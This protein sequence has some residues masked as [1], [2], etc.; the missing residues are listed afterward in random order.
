[1][2]IQNLNLNCIIFY[3][4]VRIKLVLI[5]ISS[6][7][8]IFVFLKIIN[9]N[10]ISG[11]SEIPILNWF[12]H[13]IIYISAIFTLLF[14]PIYP[15]IF[16]IFKKKKLNFLEKLSIT[17]VANLSF[18]II[19]GISGFYLGF[20]LTEW[21][22]FIILIVIYMII[23]FW[24]LIV[25]IKKGKFNTFKYNF[26]SDD[27]EDFI[28]NF[29]I[30]S[31]IKR[32][33]VSNSVLL[34]IF[35]FLLCILGVFGSSIFIGTDPWMHISVIKFITDIN[36][37]P[38]GDYFGTFGFHI[39][40]ALIHFFSGMEI[41]LIPRF[42][43]FYTFPITTL[44]VYNLFM[45]IFRN[46]NLAIFGI[47]VLGFSSLGFLNLM[48]QFWP[49][50]L[51]LIQGITLF[52]LLYTRLQSFT[53][54][55][56]PHKNQIFS[57]M[58]FSYF[59]FI[60]IF[61]SCI[62]I[63]SLIAMIFLISFLLVYSIY[64][65]KSYRRGFDFILLC[66][67]L[68]I[69]VIFYFLNISTGH[70]IVFMKL[71]SLPWYYI[72]FGTI[73]IGILEALVL[74]HYRKSMDFTKGRFSLIS[75]GKKSR[76]FKKIEE[77]FLIPLI[78]TFAIIL[79]FA[80]GIANL[81]L[82]KFDFIAVFTGLEIIIICS[83]AIWGLLIFQYK[84]RGKPLFLWGLAFGIILIAGI[85]FDFFT[86]S[87]T[88]SSRIFYLSSIMISVGFVSYFYK[89]MK[90]KSIQHLKIKILMVFIVSFSL[91]A[92]N[93]EIYSSFEFYSLKR[94]EVSIIQWYSD[95]SPNQNAVIGEFGW[96]SIIIYYDYPFEENNAS[97]SLNSVVFFHA[98]SNEYLNPN[99]HI[100]N[101]TNILVDLK[102]DLETDVY[103]ILT[104]SFLLISSLELFGRLTSEEMEMYYSL[105]YLN[106][107][108]ST[109]TEDGNE[110]PL[111]WVI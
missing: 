26:A 89:L 62:L 48:Y 59:L 5:L 92:T 52:F 97:L 23:V 93:Y 1:M 77:R 12:F 68:C 24:I 76:F 11:L 6:I 49:S 41:I 32:F 94:R 65:I 8:L 13:F 40:G 47:F 50:S 19:V 101:G 67:C 102:E 104:D 81:F 3:I 106:K 107:I 33:R 53:Q 60:G 22:F 54:E 64:F 18:Y 20:A 108:C 80:F 85:L 31:L 17:I 83:F 96:S 79:A 25:D 35:I 87:F 61:I 63:H 28:N 36:Y 103:V 4:K 7:S 95:F 39:F 46:K 78:F 91:V 15:I 111:Y 55:K 82:F 29:S 90:T 86:G 43:M 69:F 109:K 21:F 71:G 84:P 27:K 105:N 100:Q 44:I 9:F 37:L 30:L 34:G 66:I 57:N 88:F 98:A 56:E 72:L 16:I 51:A 99:L 38:S 14:L 74:L 42:F 110:V 2:R 10:I 70:L 58:Y 75:S 45:R 73:L